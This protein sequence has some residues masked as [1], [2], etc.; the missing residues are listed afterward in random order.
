MRTALHTVSYAGIWPG[1]AQLSL[2]NIIDKAA[3]MG[4]D[5]VEIMA[6]RPHASL[7]DLA[8][9]ARKRLREQLEA[10]NLTVSCLAG[11]N[12]FG[13]SIE[14]P[15]VPAAEIQVFYV[16]ELA[17]LA[18]DLGGNLV[19]I[20]TAFERESASFYAH[21][22]R[23]VTA[24][25]EAGKRAADAGVIIG[26]QNHHDL[27]AHYLSL[28]DLLEEIN[29]PNVRAVFDAWAV[30]LHGDDP[31][32]A[33][34]KMAPYIAYTTAAD[35]VRRPRYTYQP[36]LVNYLP[37]TDFIKAVPMGEGMV[38]YRSFLDTLKSVGYS[39]FVGY[40]M[41]S[42]LTGGGDETNLDKCASRFLAFMKPW[43]GK[44]RT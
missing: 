39:G 40:E 8:P 15:D 33:V 1:Q 31:A 37:E 30:V 32:A 35:Y 5:G 41:C 21:W 3:G 25:R 6:K 16:A 19:R 29:E 13:M 10:R 34:R 17:K 9:D 4:F 44:D 23:C 20:F 18:R 42:P 26:V 36:P 24:I 11:Y 7:L 43:R 27:A 28:F 22:Q 12:D 14:R 38:D 2:E